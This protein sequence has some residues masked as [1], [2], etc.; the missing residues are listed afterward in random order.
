MKLIALPFNIVE[1]NNEIFNNQ[2]QLWTGLTNLL[3]D[4]GIICCPRDSNRINESS[5][6]LFSFIK[7]II[8][9]EGKVFFY[10]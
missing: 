1:N 5:E 10:E 4:K 3:K 2:S 8:S 9:L 7:V 6:T